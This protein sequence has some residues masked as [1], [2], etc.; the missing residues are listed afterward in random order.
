MGHDLQIEGQ[1]FNCGAGCL[2]WP[3]THTGIPWAGKKEVFLNLPGLLYVSLIFYLH[4]YL[5][6]YIYTHFLYLVCVKK[7][8]HT[9]K[10][11][12]LNENFFFSPPTYLFSSLPW[13][14]FTL[15]WKNKTMR[16]LNYLAC[17]E[18]NSWI[19]HTILLNRPE[20]QATGLTWS[21][22]SSWRKDLLPFIFTRGSFLSL[23][24]EA[25]EPSQARRLPWENRKL[26]RVK[27]WNMI[28]YQK[29]NS[30]SKERKN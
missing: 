2:I 3:T 9:H 30:A 18:R 6:V 20:S 26:C 29:N 15:P 4:V 23:M 7:Y 27:V 22:K 1:V 24:G 14:A 25:G 11:T 8:P 5:Y 28:S 10:G 12:K 17:R 13:E 16:E 19:A 21:R